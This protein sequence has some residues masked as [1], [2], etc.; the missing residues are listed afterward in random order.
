M[1]GISMRLALALG[2]HLR[3]E[4]PS[5]D[6]VRKESLQNTWWSLHAIECLVSSIT[7]RP[8]VIAIE[9]CTVAVPNSDSPRRP[10]NSD[11]PKGTSRRRT[12]YDTPP[13]P[14]SSSA[15]TSGKRATTESRYFVTH[16]NITFISQKVLLSLYSPRTAARSWEVGVMLRR[17]NPTHVFLY[18]HDVLILAYVVRSKQDERAT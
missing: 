3:N 6:A 9:D 8:P 4:D 5:L 15:S 1:I 2:L 18:L 13:M 7:G 14:T 17:S 16:L 10:S 11:N 12:S